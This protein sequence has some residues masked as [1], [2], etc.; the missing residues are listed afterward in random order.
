MEN[1]TVEPMTAL[2]PPALPAVALGIR[3]WLGTRMSSFSRQ[4]ETVFR[5]FCLFF[6]VLQNRLNLCFTPLQGTSTYPL[7]GSDL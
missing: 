6:T 1:L 4:L 2:A 5:Y 7:F 3:S